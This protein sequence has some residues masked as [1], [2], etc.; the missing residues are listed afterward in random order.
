M[1]RIANG[2]QRAYRSDLRAQQAEETRSRILDATV[3]VIAAGVASISIPGVAR[4]AGVSIPTVY[5]HFGTKRDLLA[6]VY[7]HL[8]RQSG[9]SE[10]IAPRNMEEFGQ[11]VR[12]LFG[13]MGSFDEMSRA[14]IFSPA[15]DEVRRISMPER[16]AKSRAF[17]RLVAP[18][19]SAADLERITRI[20]VVLTN[21]AAMRIWRD[22]LGS[23][24]DEAADDIV[25]ILR[26][27]IATAQGR[28][29]FS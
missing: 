5:R 2:T 21:S 27:A 23:S 24:V 1:T 13:R 26:A 7:P 3:R 29:A 14:A 22:H 4:E 11:M 19:A 6:A 12:Q 10:L 28:K 15:A 18:G 17:A 8:V 16:I 25:W 20:F 9:H